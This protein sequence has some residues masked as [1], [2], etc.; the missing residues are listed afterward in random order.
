LSE[1]NGAGPGFDLLRL[2]LAVIILVGHCSGMSGTGG[3]M[4]AVMQNFLQFVWPVGEH[5]ALF[6]QIAPTVIAV[7]ENGAV[8]GL[9]RP[10][11]ISHVPMFFALSGFLVTGSAFRAKRVLPFLALRF[12]RIFPALLVEVTLSAIIIGAIF[13]SLSPS[14]YYTSPG[15]WTYFGNIIGIVQLTLPGVQFSGSQIN[16]IVNG[17]LWT[18]PAEFHSYL[19]AAL[20]MFIGVIFNRA[21]YS[22]IFLVVT[23]VLL[24]LNTFFDYQVTMAR[25]PGD[26][27]VYYFFVGSLFYVWR[28]KI[29][30][31]LWLF[32]PCVVLTYFL[33]FSTRTVYLYPALLV[34]ITVFI[35]LTS[36]PK[37]RLLQSGDYSYGIYLY[38]FPIAQALVATVPALRH[39]LLGLATTATIVTGLCAFL[40]WHLIEKRFLRLR[41]YFSV[42]SAKIAEDLHPESFQAQY[43]RS[44]QSA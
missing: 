7:Q 28:D 10:F 44:R 15:F 39:N 25:L 11:T 34:Y 24:V 41:K 32:T 5:S 18:L 22:Y 4:S 17:N 20:L 19:I 6:Q 36:F 27:N 31:S 14:E 1:N 3:F 13:S 8:I 43:A 42:Q 33:I 9:A 16:E 2:A 29:P 30:Y 38:G 37:F 21:V 26:V 12:F 35:G 40:S 23:V